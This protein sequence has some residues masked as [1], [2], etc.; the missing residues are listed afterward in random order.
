MAKRRKLSKKAS[1]KSFRKG[2]RVNKMNGSAK[3]MRGGIR[4]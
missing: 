2:T 4:L 3:I 1:R